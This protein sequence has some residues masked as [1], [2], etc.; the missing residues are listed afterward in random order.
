[1]N[2]AVI[3]LVVYKASGASINF[4]KEECVKE[5]ISNDFV[6]CNELNVQTAAIFTLI[7]CK[8]VIIKCVIQ[9]IMSKVNH[10]FDGM[11]V[12]QNCVDVLE[13]EPG[14]HTEKR[15]MASNDGNQVAGIKVEDAIGIKQEDDLVPTTS[16]FIKTEPVVSPMSVQCAVLCTLLRYPELHNLKLAR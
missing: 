15:L 4:R 3:L 1:M 14:S 10:N 6:S 9:Y 16:A 5:F 13:S 8:M 11:T 7:E 12:L 2:L